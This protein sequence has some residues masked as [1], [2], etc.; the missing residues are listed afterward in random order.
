MYA[1]LFKHI[2]NGDFFS[3]SKIK[4]IIKDKRTRLVIREIDFVLFCLGGGVSGGGVQE[5]LSYENKDW[6]LYFNWFDEVWYSES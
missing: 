5:Y 6:S 4:K 1:K 2:W 3:H